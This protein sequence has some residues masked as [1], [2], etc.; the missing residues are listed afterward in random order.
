M[1]AILIDVVNKEVKEIEIGKGIDEMYKFLNCD[2]FTVASYLPNED[3]IFVD[4]EGLMKGT[5][6]FF[7]YQEAHQP[8]AGNGLIMGCDEDGES[9]DCK[10]S[11]DEVKSRV[12]FYSRH[13]L[14][15]AMSFG[16][17]KSF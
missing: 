14:A 10:I 12:E 16:K 13:G 17:V 15:M 11:L 9:V 8:F 4:D 2:C 6:E 1:K 5:D 3:A 7:T